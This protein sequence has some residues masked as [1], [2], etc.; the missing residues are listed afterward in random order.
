VQCLRTGI[1]IAEGFVDVGKHLRP[2]FRSGK[3]VL[4][5]EP[6]AAGGDCAWQAVKLT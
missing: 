5:V 3:I 6:A 4:F 1:G 2:N